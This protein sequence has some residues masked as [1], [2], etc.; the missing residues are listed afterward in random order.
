MAVVEYSRSGDL[1]LCHLNRPERLNAVVPELVEELCRCL[2]RAADEKVGAF[3]LG[4]RGRAFCA[5]HD[6]RQDDSTLTPEQSLTQL[7]RVQDVTRKI[8]R[9]PFPVIA[10]VH[11]YALGAGCEF[12]LCCDLIIAARD[13]TFG[14]PE[15]SVGLGV[16]GGISH[17][18]PLAVGMARAKELIMGGQHF[19]A[20]QA[21]RWGLVNRVVEAGD[22][23]RVSLGLA[24]E[25]ASRPSESMAL[26]KRSLDRGPQA[27]LEAAFSVEIAH[28]E[29]LRTSAGA[30]KAAAEFRARKSG[31]PSRGSGTKA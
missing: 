16:T 13:A 25:L 29:L 7:E 22:L 31:S 28:A 24:R 8:R 19:D 5:G 1:A 2:D 14:F 23:E 11:G 17:I 27:D 15:V 4:G 21:A 12:A 10:A 6:L 9:A 30:A 26:N 20:E 18:L 3:V